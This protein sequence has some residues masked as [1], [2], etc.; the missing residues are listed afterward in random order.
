MAFGLGSI[1]GAI[2]S[3][4]SPIASIASNIVSA[5][6][7]GSAPRGAPQPIFLP[8]P[9]AAAP[10]SGLMLPVGLPAGSFR[11]GSQV[12]PTVQPVAAGALVPFVAGGAAALVRGILARASAFIGTRISSAR[13]LA[14]VRDVGLVSAAAALGLTAVE[15]AQIIAA[16]PR[17]RRRGIT[18]RDISTTKRVIRTTHRIQHDLSHLAAPVRRRHHHHRAAR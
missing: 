4:V 8:A 18:A 10:T 14:L 11:F 9:V 13:V 6:G 3:V 17:R 5:F 1:L 2:S 12:G 15:V 7:G 16:K